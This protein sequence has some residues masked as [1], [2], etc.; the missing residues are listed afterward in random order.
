MWAAR[1]GRTSWGAQAEILLL[2]DEEPAAVATQ[3]GA[4]VDYSTLRPVPVPAEFRAQFEAA[5]G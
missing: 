1:L 2:P 5:Q 4:F 3:A